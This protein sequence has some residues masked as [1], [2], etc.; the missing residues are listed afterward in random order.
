MQ[1]VQPGQFTIPFWSAD[2][3]L[4]YYR[5]GQNPFAVKFY[6]FPAIGGEQ[7]LV[8]DLTGHNFAVAAPRVGQYNI[9]YVI[10]EYSSDIWVMDLVED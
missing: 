5:T 7:Q 2:G 9:Y 10:R 6:S 1:A 8:L 4:M 3:S